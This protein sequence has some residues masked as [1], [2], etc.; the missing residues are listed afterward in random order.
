MPPKSV[1]TFVLNSKAEP[2]T[3]KS[4]PT[5][6]SP[7]IV[8]PVTATKSAAAAAEAVPKFAAVIFPV[9]STSPSKLCFV[10]ASNVVMLLRSA[11][12]FGSKDSPVL[13]IL[14][15]KKAPEVS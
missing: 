12:N 6:K 9:M 8:S 3:K 5:V 1:T 15:V 10:F 2:V 13:T 7:V 4:A 11:A 14:P